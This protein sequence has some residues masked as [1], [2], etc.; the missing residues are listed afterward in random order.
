MLVTAP[1]AFVTTQVAIGALQYL[2][3]LASMKPSNALGDPSGCLTGAYTDVSLAQL[4]LRQLRCAPRLPPS[5]PD[6][7]TVQA[8]HLLRQPGRHCMH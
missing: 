2:P 1:T 3:A 5:H 7:G 4:L 6:T 8:L